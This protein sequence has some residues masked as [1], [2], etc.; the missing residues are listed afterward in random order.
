M[1]AS[2]GVKMECPVR[3]KP[4]TRNDTCCVLWMMETEAVG[5]DALERDAPFG[6]RNQ[7]A[8]QAGLGQYEACG[9][10]GDVGRRRDGDA[11]LSLPQCR[12]IVCAIPTHPD[13]ISRPL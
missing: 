12:S 9:R 11:E 8:P 13:E 10:L 5:Q 4:A 2:I 1:T 7:N 6:H 3:I